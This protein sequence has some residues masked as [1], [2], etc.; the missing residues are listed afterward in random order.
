MPTYYGTG[1]RNK[2]TGSNA[3]DDLFG[4]G[5]D[6]V[7]YG[8]DG[9]DTLDGG[10]G[11]DEMYGGA[12]NDTYFV[13]DAGD[14]VIE[15]ENQGVD[16]VYASLDYTLPDHVEALTLKG[17]AAVYGGGND[18]SNWIFG[19][20]LANRLDGKG[21]VDTMEGGLGNDTYY[22][23]RTGDVVVEYYDEGIDEVVSS[24]PTYTL[25]ANV[26]KLTLA[27]GSEVREGIGNTL[28]NQLVGNSTDN[29]LDGRSGAD[30]M[31]GGD[32]DDR[33]VVDN[34]QDKVMEDA[35][36][37]IDVVWS[38]V[39]YTLSAN[40]EDLVLT[41][42]GAMNG[43]GNGLDN[44]L[45]G[46]DGTN[47]LFG[48]GGDDTL[49]GGGGFD[50]LRGGADNDTY[51]VMDTGD[52]VLENDGEGIDEV[53]A[54]IDYTLT[55]NVENLTLIGSP[56]NGMPTPI[57]GAGNALDNHIVGNDRNN[58]L[59]GEQGNDTIDGMSGADDMYGG[60][61]D[62]YYYVDD[63]GDDVFEY[64]NE[65]YDTVEAAISYT[66]EAN[67]EKLVLKGGLGNVPEILDAAYADGNTAYNGT[68]N[69]LDNVIM[70]NYL[71][72]VIDGGRGS[73]TLYGGADADT[74]VFDHIGEGS[75]HDV[76]KDFQVGVDL[77]DLDNTSIQNFDD[78]FTPGDRYMEQVGD[79]VL[80]HTSVSGGT[81]ILLENVQLSSLTQSD[82]LF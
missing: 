20:K 62:D 16:R 63:A 13:D 50:F 59:R 68:G 54:Y 31:R 8:L 53:I 4:Y 1:N 32:G 5:D 23:D 46:G 79:D 24:A 57:S 10:A 55:G 7:L 28:P 2:L 47:F 38:S 39:T 77:I 72:N 43:Y 60:Q 67:V 29:V 58:V 36:Q 64:A 74:F 40:V 18:G 66:L 48:Y 49:Y 82:F 26:E 3:N 56:D 44:H 9:E 30:T 81:S 34:A 52:A 11:A 75:Q 80:I 6:D 65:G 45:W 37:G 41:G 35:D 25:S 61:D 21:G 69:A 70:G 19:N 76:I 22:V 15:K 78:L 12:N 33:Y 14:K 42:A 71:A 27:E 73:D 51:I 17:A